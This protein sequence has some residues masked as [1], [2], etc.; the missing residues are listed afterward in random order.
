[1]PSNINSKY[2]IIVGKSLQ[3]WRLIY[4][5]YMAHMLCHIFPLFY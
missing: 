5:D 3:F 1:M 2:V 4:M